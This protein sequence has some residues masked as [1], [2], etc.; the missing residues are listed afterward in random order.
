MKKITFALFVFF[1]FNISSNFAFAANFS[2]EGKTVT[3]TGVVVCVEENSLVLATSKAVFVFGNIVNMDIYRFPL[4]AAGEH[5]QWVHIQI[6]PVPTE[7]FGVK[8][9]FLNIAPLR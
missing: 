9:V 8:I 1:I 5:E 3:L 7:E 2:A 6:V 4:L